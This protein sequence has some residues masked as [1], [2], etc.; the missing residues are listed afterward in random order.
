M[1]LFNK[2]KPAGRL[3]LEVSP[4][5]MSV[6]LLRDES[7]PGEREHCECDSFEGTNLVDLAAEVKAWANDRRV[8]EAPCRVVPHPSYYSFYF[9]E[10]PEGIE[11]ADVDAAVKWKVKDLIDEPLENVMIDTF[12]VPADAFHGRSE[13]LYA[14]AARRALIEEIAVALEDVGMQIEAIDI[15]E[16]VAGNVL[17]KVDREGRATALLRMRRSDGLINLSEGGNLYVMRHIDTS[18]TL[19]ASANEE[20]QFEVLDELLLEV[21]RSLDYFDSQIGKGRVRQFYLAPMRVGRGNV[22]EHLQ[23]NLGVR[24]RELDLNEI[25]ETSETLPG[26]VQ[27]QCFAAVAV[28]CG[29]TIH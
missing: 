21:Q 18:L 20:E 2:S 29:T 28:A 23:N 25:F 15:T 7:E 1:R 9:V 26:N 22:Q 8:L 3:C 27:A 5:G 14:V 16:L 13:M 24:I 11:D 4:F 6:A 17:R 10:R 19:L 12:P